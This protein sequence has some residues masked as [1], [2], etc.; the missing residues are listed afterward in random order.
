MG[1]TRAAPLVPTV[2][3][4]KRIWLSESY[5][6]GAI[7]PDQRCF[8]DRPSGVTNAYALVGG[9]D[10]TAA[11]RLKLTANYVRPD[12]MLVGTGQQLVDKTILTGI[13]QRGNGEY[14]RERF[15]TVWSGAESLTSVGTKDVTCDNWTSPSGALYGNVGDLDT[16]GVRYWWTFARVPCDAYGVPSRVIRLYCVEP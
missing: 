2:S 14:Y 10:R 6:A 3:T 1:K 5:R 13:W 11:S 7:S 4:G 15:P 12:G 16:I 9:T 8:A